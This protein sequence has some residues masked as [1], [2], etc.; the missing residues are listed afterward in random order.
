MYV[1][2]ETEY[3]CVNRSRLL[4]KETTQ[5]VSIIIFCCSG[6]LA[7]SDHHTV[8]NIQIT[9]HRTAKHNTPYITNH[10]EKE[11]EERG[12]TCETREE[13]EDRIAARH[14]L[15]FSLL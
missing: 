12:D 9:V 14:F 3:L 1:H 6:V 13:P 5:T 10:D 8:S 7:S 2:D 4:H 15:V 11:W